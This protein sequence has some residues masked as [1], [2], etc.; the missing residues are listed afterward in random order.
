M[1]KFDGGVRPKSV[2][3]LKS[4]QAAVRRVVRACE[5]ATV[6]VELGESVGSGV[7]VSAHGLVLTAGHVSF[8]PNQKVWLRFADGPRYEGLTLGVNHPVDS[9]AVQI[10]SPPPDEAGWPFVPLSEEDVE[11][12][13]WVVAMGQ[14]NGFVRGRTPPV[15]LGRV[16]QSKD[17]TLGTDATLVGGDSGGPLMN[18][19]GAVVGIHSRIGARIT[20]NYHVKASA[21]RRDWN[22]LMAGQ[23]DGIPDGEDAWDWGPLAGIAVRERGAGLVVSQVFTGSPAEEAG[24]QGGDVVVSVGGRAV[25]TIIELGRI[26]RGLEPYE[27]VAIVVRRA[28]GERTLSLWIGRGSRGYPGV[29]PEAFQ[30]GSLGAFAPRSRGE[31]E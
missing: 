10:T 18:L 4:L 27:R 23:L 12:G 30:P 14:P 24:F 2:E 13:D 6:Q 31:A 25:E 20:S 28:A 26:A 22:A 5:P 29:D 9:G 7:V 19:Q 17:D 16:L 15:R 8:E 11:A 3:D 1:K 21:F